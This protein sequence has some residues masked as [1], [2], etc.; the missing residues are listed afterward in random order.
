MLAV[1]LE[2]RGSD[3]RLQLLLRMRL[4]LLYLCLCAWPPGCCSILGVVFLGLSLHQ[5]F[6]GQLW[7]VV[8]L[9][10][11]RSFLACSFG[12]DEFCFSRLFS[13]AFAQDPLAILDSNDVSAADLLTI[14]AKLQQPLSGNLHTEPNDAAYVTPE[15]AC[16]EFLQTVRMMHESFTSAGML[17]KADSPLLEYATMSGAGK[18]RWGFQVA[19]LLREDEN[20]K[21]CVILRVGL[22]FNGGS[23]GGDADRTE[24]VNLL[25]THRFSSQQIMASLLFARGLLERS[26]DDFRGQESRLQHLRLRTVLDALFASAQEAGTRILVVHL[27]ELAMLLKD[28]SFGFTDRSLKEFVNNLADY[29]CGQPLGVVVPIITHTSP[30]VWNPEPTSIPLKRM[31]L[32]AFNF[33][34][35]LQFFVGSR[36]RR[37]LF[38]DMSMPC[39]HEVC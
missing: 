33:N 34:Q 38:D 4:G 19:R 21:K 14:K 13:R 8:S 20:F 9:L 31:N 3:S 18:T 11:V 23:G 5:R 27:D 15:N 12:F 16:K 35:S 32:G 17:N 22:N 29:N 2:V 25:Q 36:G 24:A 7:A 1:G 30:V 28:T 37:L 26:P 6:A 39:M 10:L